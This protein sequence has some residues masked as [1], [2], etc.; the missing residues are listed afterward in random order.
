MESEVLAV[1]RCL[2]GGRDEEREIVLD[3]EQGP[4]LSAANRFD[5]DETDG[6]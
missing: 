6:R 3:C 2:D 5:T 1:H 4:G